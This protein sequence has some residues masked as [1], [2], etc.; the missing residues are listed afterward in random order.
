MARSVNAGRA[1]AVVG[2]WVGVWGWFTG[3][4]QGSG[5]WSGWGR[6]RVGFGPAPLGGLFLGEPAA[7]D[8]VDL[9]A[10]GGAGRSV[11]DAGVAGLVLLV[12]RGRGTGGGITGGRVLDRRYGDGV[13]AAGQV[14]GLP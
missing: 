14:A 3:G 6:V 10:D 4:L 12:R 9:T 1:S 13:H 7:V 5:K 11:P 2:V 8:V